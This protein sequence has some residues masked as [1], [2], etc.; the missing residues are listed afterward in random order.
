[1]VAVPLNFVVTLDLVHYKSRVEN[2]SPLNKVECTK[3]QALTDNRVICVNTNPSPTCREA[4][5]VESK[6]DY[7]GYNAET[8]HD[9]MEHRFMFMNLVVVIHNDLIQA[10]GDN[11]DPKGTC[12]SKYL[13]CKRNY[14]SNHT[15]IRH[16]EPN[17][18]KH[19]R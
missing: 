19:I 13:C 16:E 4:I 7:A 18:S 14:L 5:R 11:R 17:S 3:S 1:V 6:W 10:P 9:E 8:P 12:V 2:N 15:V